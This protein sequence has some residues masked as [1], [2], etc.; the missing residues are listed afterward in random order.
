M[1]LANVMDQVAA[2][3]DTITGLRVYE[4]PPDNLAP[5]AAWI[6]YPE[7]Y[8]FDTTYGRGTDRIANLPV[9]VAVARV[10]DRAAR[11]LVGAYVDGAGPASVKQVVESGTY[12]AFDTVRV[13]GVTF[14]ILTRGGTDYLAALFMLDIIGP[15]SA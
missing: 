4:F 9:I 6:G 12:T 7:G 15:G 14:D 1:N 2:R 3:L 11:D 8:E 13:T 10:S 5:P